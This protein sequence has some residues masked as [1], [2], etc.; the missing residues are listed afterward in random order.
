MNSTMNTSDAAAPG[1]VAAVP[2]GRHQGCGFA[3][4]AAGR[5]DPAELRALAS[6]LRTAEAFG[7]EDV[8]DPRETRA[9]LCR[10]LDA[11]QGRLKSDVGPKYKSGVRP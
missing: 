2:A 1:A 10:F 7:V 6:P 8:I 9:Y 3:R 5:A 4:G 11:M